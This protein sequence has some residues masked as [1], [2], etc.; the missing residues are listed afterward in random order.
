[1]NGSDVARKLCILARH[2]P[3]V[4]A[5]PEGYASVPTESLVP[6]VLQ[7]AD[8]KEAYLERLAEGDAYFDKVRKEA[9]AEGKVVRYVGVLDVANGKVECKLGKYPF[10]H[11]F[12]TSLKGSD[13]MIS[14]STER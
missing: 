13:N 5:L 6:E 2:I 12:A 3:S 11:P 10:D 9:F 8:T 4:P 7:D 1:M 14:F